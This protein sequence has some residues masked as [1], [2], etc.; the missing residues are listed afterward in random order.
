[1]IT[2][3]DNQYLAYVYEFNIYLEDFQSGETTQL[4]F[5]GSED[6][7]NGTF[8]WAY[9]EEF[10]KRDGFS[11]S[12]D[13]KQIA[14]WQLDAMRNCYPCSIQRWEKSLRQQKSGW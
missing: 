4:T 5:D 8:D 9:E 3:F 14:F 10:G 13:A 1:M 2:G 11:W 6:I 7:I 12:P